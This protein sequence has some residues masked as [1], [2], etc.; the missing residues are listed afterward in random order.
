[1]RYLLSIYFWIFFLF[2]TYTCALVIL[3]VGFLN[4]L[5]FNGRKKSDHFTHRV[6]EFWA[7]LSLKAIP[8]WDIHIEGRENLD[9]ALGPYV[10]T[11]NHESMADIWV[12]YLMNTQFRWLAKDS[13]FKIPLVGP[14]MREGGYVAIVR[15]DRDSHGKALEQSRQIL[16]NGIN[17]FF[18]PEGT[19]ST[20]GIKRFKVGAF[21]IAKEEKRPILP[22]VI[23]GAANLLPKN[24][25]LVAPRARIDIAFL[26]PIPASFFENMDYDAAAEHTRSLIIEK[27][28]QI[29]NKLKQD[30]H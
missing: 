30:A 24:S 28:N 26:K 23:H 19:R 10:I 17:M 8:G 14:A 11:S 25:W 5:L 21:K 16:R 1:M 29:L 18:F 13:L 4:R 27:H 12:A 2:V 9:P 7:K 6:A 22:M 20:E 15:G 3:T